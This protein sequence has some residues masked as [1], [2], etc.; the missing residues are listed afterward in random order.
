VVLPTGID[1]AHP[2]S[3]ADELRRV[4]AAGAVVVSEYPPATPASS[5]RLRARARLL[6][7][8]SAMTVAV[9]PSASGGAIDVADWAKRLGRAVAVVPGPLAS[10]DSQGTHH[11]MRGGAAT[12]ACA[13]DL[14]ALLKPVRRPVGAR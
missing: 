13:G 2:T 6:A 1:V 4:K 10:S 14:R 11:L 3:N 12:I 7:A 5:Y 8:G 9:E